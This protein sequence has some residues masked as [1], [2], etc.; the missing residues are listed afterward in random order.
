MNKPL[1]LITGAS[2]GL[3][4]ETAR[5]MGAMGYRLALAAQDEGRLAAAAK[6]LASLGHD[7]R[8]QT[9]DMSHG[10]SVAALGKW[11][12]ALG[13]LASVVNS[14]GILPGQGYSEPA[15]AAREE[16][17]AAAIAVNSLGPWRLLREVAPAIQDG[18][19]IVNVS[20]GLGALSDMGGGYFAYR[21][22]KAMLN[23][24]TRTV[25]AELAPRG[26]MVNSVCPGWVKTDMGGP[27]ATRAIP[28]GASGIVWAAT[29]K[30]GGPTGGFFRDGKKIDW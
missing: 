17:V 28:E 27:N 1:V 16:D 6:E 2:R 24:L 23:V 3:G 7:V 5:Q 9:V 26:I 11:A 8:T 19:T 15:L 29:L 10:P 30:P 21:S 4:L 20:S 13:P 22:S 14:A 18:G 25:A 12:A